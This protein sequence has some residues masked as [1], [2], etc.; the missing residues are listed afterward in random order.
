MIRRPPRSTRTDTLFPY[1]TLFRSLLFEQ[2][3]ARLFDLRAQGRDPRIDIGCAARLRVCVASTV[4]LQVV[5]GIGELLVV[6]LHLLVDELVR[7]AAFPLLGG[8]SFPDEQRD[9]KSFVVGQ[10]FAVLVALGGR[11]VSKNK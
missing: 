3:H 5:L 1:T 10:G 9:R 2:G 11:R 4:F 7:F 8:Q 6:R